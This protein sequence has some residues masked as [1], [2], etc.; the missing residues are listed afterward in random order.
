MKWI[1]AIL[2]AVAAILLV[3]PALLIGSTLYAVVVI[4]VT[5]GSI[6]ALRQW[7][8]S[9][10][11]ALPLIAIC[12]L[13]VVAQFLGI[14][15]LFSAISLMLAVYAWNVGNRFGHL[16]HA[17]V[18]QEAERQ[19]VLQIL[20]TS[21]IPSIAAGLFLTAFLYVRFS[22]PFGLGLGLSAAA[23]LSVA[24]FMVLARAMRKHED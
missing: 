12:G 18:E 3:L 10:Q 7:P 9:A 24:L 5:T 6:L 11:S 4:L 23:L 22:M 8:N 1:T 17:R 19:F 16:G 20:I 14:H 21:L 2:L 13:A 15:P